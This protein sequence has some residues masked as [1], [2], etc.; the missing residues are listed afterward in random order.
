MHMAET[1][2]AEGLDPTSVALSSLVPIVADLYVIQRPLHP[3]AP[4]D[5]TVI[6]FPTSPE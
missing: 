3:A 5:S 1:L 6:A 4:K 2:I